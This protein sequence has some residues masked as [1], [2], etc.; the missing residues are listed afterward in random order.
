MKLIEIV[1]SIQQFQTEANYP[2]IL[3]IISL[4]WVQK[5]IHS[6]K[7]DAKE[8]V[9]MKPINHDIIDET[10][11]NV[12]QYEDEQFNTFLKDNLQLN[13]DYI[14]INEQIWSSLN[15]IYPGYCVKRQLRNQ[16]QINQFILF[17]F[18]PV[19]KSQKYY[20]DGIQQFDSDWTFQQIISQLEKALQNQLSLQ[21]PKQNFIKLYVL[22]NENQTNLNKIVQELK[23]KKIELEIIENKDQLLNKKYLIMDIKEYKKGYYFQQ[24]LTKNEIVNEDQLSQECIENCRK[25]LSIFEDQQS[26]LSCMLK[27]YECIDAI[28]NQIFNDSSEKQ[29]QKYG[30]RELANYDIF[31]DQTVIDSSQKYQNL[32][33]ILEESYYG[34]SEYVYYDLLNYEFFEEKQ[35]TITKSRYDAVYI[36]N[37]ENRIIIN[38]QKNIR[39]LVESL[40]GHPQLYCDF[41][42]VLFESS[43]EFYTED[44]DFMKPA[45]SLKE[46]YTYQLRKL[47]WQEHNINNEDRIEIRV[48]QCIYE[49]LGYQEYKPFAPIQKCYISQWGKFQDLHLLIAN[50]FEEINYDNY[51]EHR[52]NK[53]YTM[54]FQT[55]QQGQIKCSF[56]MQKFCNNCQVPFNDKPLKFG[57]RIINIYV[58]YQDIQ[59]KFSRYQP[60]IFDNYFLRDYF[61]VDW[62]KDKILILNINQDQIKPYNIKYY[63]ESNHYQLHGIIEKLSQYEYQCYCRKNQQWYKFTQNK[64]EQVNDLNDDLD[65]VKLFYI[66]K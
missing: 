17:N 12:I 25:G 50:L 13:V 45:Y 22:K 40:L 11:S 30:I 5:L 33:E 61:E 23:D 26:L 48:H 37:N 58:I 66:R 63:F 41:N 7:L 39:Q 49:N 53:K 29:E 38:N 51:K 60:I 8:N 15:N 46:G 27:C 19:Y 34:F 47:M 55:D 31:E 20:I 59:C 44:I 4:N 52:L 32:K 1:Q 62:A 3:Y 24:S 9:P 57:K 18:I 36:Y 10:K 54:Y 14:Y 21:T 16:N 2:N 35:V 28:R 56:C 6:V 65:V 64:Y 42:S 43:N